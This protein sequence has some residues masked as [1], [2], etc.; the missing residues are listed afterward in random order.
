MLCT[1]HV[2][3]IYTNVRVLI[4]DKRKE[5]EITKMPSLV[6]EHINITVNN[7]ALRS[8]QIFEYYYLNRLITNFCQD[9]TSFIRY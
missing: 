4:Y 2:S 8:Y 5:R 9:V 3:Y 7:G 6:L 1:A